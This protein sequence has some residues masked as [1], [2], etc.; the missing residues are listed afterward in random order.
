MK[1]DARRCAICLLSLETTIAAVKSAGRNKLTSLGIDWHFPS[2]GPTY[3]KDAPFIEIGF[4]LNS[5]IPGYIES[6]VI[7]R[8]DFDEATFFCRARPFANVFR[9]RNA[10]A[11][12]KAKS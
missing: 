10:L 4:K 5:L 2:K 1:L 11:A 8:S 9:W 3:L 6:F 12:A 7:Y